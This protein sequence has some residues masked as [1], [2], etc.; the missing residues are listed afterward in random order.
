M[1]KKT[2]E[3]KTYKTTEPKGVTIHR[4]GETFTL[5][6][7]IT[8]KDYGEGQTAQYRVNSGKWHTLSGVKA[9]TTSKTFTIHKSGY[10]PAKSGTY[11]HKV[12]ARVRGRRKDFRKETKTEIQP[13]NTK[14][15]DWS[16]YTFT[17]TSPPAPTVSAAL[18]DTQTNVTTFSW[19]AK[20][21]E[22]GWFDSVKWESVLIENCNTTNGDNVTWKNTTYG[23]QSGTGGTSGSRVITEPTTVLAGKSYTRWFRAIS[24][25]PRSNSGW[26]YARHV[27]AVPLQAI[28]KRA[29]VKV[30][31]AGGYLCTAEWEA[32]QYIFRPIDK[33][34]VQYCI[35]TPNANLACPPGASWT[36]ANVSADTQGVNKNGSD[37]H[38][39][40]KAEFSIDTQIAD[41]QCIWVRVNTHHDTYVTYG[42]PMRAAVGKLTEPS[43]LSVQADSSTYRAQVAATNNS[44]VPDSFLV[45]KYITP[46]QPN[47]FDIGFIPHGSTTATVQCP[48]WSD[49]TKVQFAVYAVQGSSRATTRADGVTSYAVSPNMKSDLVKG[50]GLV[51]AAPTGVRVS[52]S[53][54][55]GTVTVEFNWAWQAATSAEISWADH[56]D[57][58]ESTDEPDTY[59]IRNTHASRWNISG[60]ETGVTW[61][62]RVRLIQDSGESQTYGAYS[63]TVSIDLSSAPVVPALSVSDGVITATGNFTATWTYS[64]TDGTSQSYA[65]V[66][67]LISGEYVPIAHTETAQ[68]VT[69]YA[70]ELEWDTGET[71]AIAVRVAS[72]S[73]RFSDDWSEPAYITIAE[74]L[75]V[76]INT[77]SLVP[78]TIT[79]DGFSRNINALTVLPLTARIT[80]AGV[81]GTT[82]LIIERAETYDM[83]RP[84]ESTV[85]GFEGETVA[86]VTIAG[87]GEI[88]VSNDDLIG[89]LDDGAGYR[90]IAIAQDSYGQSAQV[91]KP[92]EVH[93]AHQAVIPSATVEIDNDNMVAFLT[94]IAPAGTAVGDTCD[95]YRLSVDKP[96]LIYPGAAFGTTYVD[97]FPTIGEYGG[98][99]FVFMTSNGDYITADN[100]LAW[101][102]T[103]EP[104]EDTLDTPYNI[105]D[106]GT[107]RVY[108]LYEI[109][110]SNSWT[111]DFT[112]T[113]YLGGSIQGDWNPAVKRS[114]TLT[115]V[116]VSADDQDLIESMRRL[117]EWAGI[118]HVRTK[119]GSSFAADVQVQED[120]KQATNQRLVN[121]SLKITRVDS[122]DYDG[123]TKAEWEETQG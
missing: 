5:S 67:E 23:Y 52:Q 44:A 69:L 49:A 81:G 115:S 106:F 10:N 113:Q 76:T 116:A 114:T 91:T 56:P 90:L 107:G 12:E 42:N 100:E 74:Q 112:E 1:A 79:V 60:L 64:T 17:F 68:F 20:D 51:P 53:D 36:D 66:A 18:S 109:D 26:R 99:R 101:T 82:T 32:P 75:T 28:N 61:Y 43:G 73:G 9:K 118:C 88:T 40:D 47:G 84:D 70:E 2:L 45:V 39:I 65:E 3:T 31:S 98:H 78:Q 54:I 103:G 13:Y 63:E 41:D 25:G 62:I 38:L 34:T 86:M 27:Y 30:T 80:G 37:K 105:I 104:E 83:A 94:P 122:E 85:I 121:F 19:S 24:R 108:L 8:D 15:S 59:T 96:V 46:Q 92:F 89:R 111:K 93:W 16:K 55:A 11:L 57:A 77:D 50:G 97:P 22:Y 119:D 14:N 72:A 35:A 58:W 102:D 120:Y 110:L 29:S 95:I 48:A 123:I 87:E 117:A 21:D 6:W 71:H 33:T 4:N 7:K